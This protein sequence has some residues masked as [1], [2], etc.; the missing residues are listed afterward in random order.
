MTKREVLVPAAILIAV[1]A[2]SCGRPERAVAE[3]PQFN[4]RENM[5][6]MHREMQRIEKNLLQEGGP[7]VVIR[8][9]D[10]IGRLAKDLSGWRM[11]DAAW[12]AYLASTKSEA[13]AE[14]RRSAE[15]RFLNDCRDQK[16]TCEA[17]SEVANMTPA[18]WNR[19]RLA[20]EAVRKSCDAC[21]KTFVSR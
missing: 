2:A 5:Q 21:H 15:A 14:A 18:E 13:S 8:A 12:S 4:V 3:P 11:D 1:A 6:A 10:E 17:L 19:L 9:S 20:A 7:P 16:R